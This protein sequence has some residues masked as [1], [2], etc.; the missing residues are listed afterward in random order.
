MV[1]FFDQDGSVFLENG[2]A[3]FERPYESGKGV[4]CVSHTAYNTLP[5]IRN[6]GREAAFPKSIFLSKHAETR[7][8]SFVTFSGVSEIVALS[9]TLSSDFLY[10]TLQKTRPNSNE[11][12]RDHSN[13]KLLKKNWLAT[14]RKRQ[15][16][17]RQVDS[18]T[19]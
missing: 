4:A 19:Y 11:Y 7:S 9:Y 3:N 18:L 16:S 17:I 15:P 6:Q 10:K 1:R 14:C 8:G 2:V 13:C 5:S 12:R